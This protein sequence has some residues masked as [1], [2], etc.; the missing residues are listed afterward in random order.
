[1]PIAEAFFGERAPPRVGKEG[2]RRGR[3]R[4]GVDGSGEFGRYRYLNRDRFPLAVLLLHIDQPTIP[5]MLSA[6]GGGVA[7]ARSNRDHQFECESRHGAERV[8]RTELRDLEVGPSVVALRFLDLHLNAYA[9][10]LVEQSD[11]R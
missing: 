3:A 11:G 2:Q 8:V 4:T 7:A 10:V 6:K 5:E 9:R 1:E